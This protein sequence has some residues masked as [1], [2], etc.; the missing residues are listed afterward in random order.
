MTIARQQHEAASTAGNRRDGLIL[1]LLGAV[2]FLALG[3]A[4]EYSASAPSRTSTH[5]TI[6][7]DA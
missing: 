6:R 1:L 7:R 2:I 3:F 4:L 5:S